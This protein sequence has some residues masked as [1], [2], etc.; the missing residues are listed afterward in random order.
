MNILGV[1][2][3]E[4]HQKEGFRMASRDP[5]DNPLTEEQ[6]KLYSDM[7]LTRGSLCG[8]ILAIEFLADY[9]LVVCPIL[10]K[11]PEWDDKYKRAIYYYSISIIVSRKDYLDKSQQP[12]YKQVV[13]KLAKFLQVIEETHHIIYDNFTIPAYADYLTS[14]LQTFRN[15]INTTGQCNLSHLCSHYSFINA[16]R[17]A[18]KQ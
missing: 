18:F 11:V 6:F 4:F 10:S 1:V 15:Q 14:I 13:A 8:R 3:S 16:G 7:I 9:F 2:L 5:L 12:L 17:P